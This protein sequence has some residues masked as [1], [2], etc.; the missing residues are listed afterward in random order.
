[1]SKTVKHEGRMELL[2]TFNSDIQAE[3][4]KVL[5][6]SYGYFAHINNSYSTRFNYY[7]SFVNTITGGIRLYTKKTQAYDAYVLLAMHDIVPMRDIVPT[8]SSGIVSFQKLMSEIPVLRS[9]GI[10]GQ[11]IVVGIII[12][13]FLVLIISLVLG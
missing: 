6:E 11:I 4:A 8:S 9:M 12:A 13:G 10:L 2:W 5:L 1:M 7:E 3:Q